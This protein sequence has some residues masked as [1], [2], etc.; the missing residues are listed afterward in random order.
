MRQPNGQFILH[1]NSENGN[2]TIVDNF[3]WF[4]SPHQFQFVMWPGLEIDVSIK[5]VANIFNKRN[6]TIVLKNYY[7]MR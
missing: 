4:E 5:H 3:I 6:M 1:Y 2:K 7:G